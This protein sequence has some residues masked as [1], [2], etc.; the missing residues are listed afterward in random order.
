MNDESDSCPEDRGSDDDDPRPG[1]AAALVV[2]VV[3]AADSWATL[4]DAPELIHRAA[5]VVAAGLG[6]GLIQPQDHPHGSGER[7]AA[8]LSGPFEAVVALSSDTE[9]RALNAS[10]RGFDKPTNVLSFPAPKTAGGATASAGHPVMIGDIVL[11]HET[12]VREAGDL[13]M[14]LAHHLQHLVIHGLLHLIGY[15][16]ETDIEAEAM[17]ALE[18]RLLADL[19]IDNPYCEA[20]STDQRLAAADEGPTT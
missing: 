15:D 2:D 19:G 4:G 17:E 8:G 18:T 16:H 3:V 11:A 1:A 5:E 20:R 14:P 12:L 9:V 10:Y 6:A 13:G 7:H